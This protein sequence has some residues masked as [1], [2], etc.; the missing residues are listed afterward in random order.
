M[1]VGSVPRTLPIPGLADR[2]IGFKNIEEAIA[3]RNR[4]LERL[5][6]A[7]SA[8]DPEVRERDLTFVFVGGGY[9]GVEAMGEAENLAR[10][11]T[12]YCTA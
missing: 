12:R 9:A 4:V 11:A 7:E 2:A 5:D 1:A 8:T 10:Y 3:L 6:I